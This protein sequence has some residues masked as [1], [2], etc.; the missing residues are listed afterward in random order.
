MNLSLRS[1]AAGLL[2]SLALTSCSTSSHPTKPSAIALFN[3]RDLAGWKHVLADPAV[4][5]DQVWSVTDGVIVCRGTPLGYLGTTRDFTNFRLSVEYRWAPGTKPGNSG[6]FS[7]I[8]DPVRALPRCAEVQLMH[9]NAGD[10]LTLQGMRLGINQARYFHV[11]QHEVAGDIDGVKKTS[12][13]EAA[14]GSWNRVEVQAEG[15]LYRVWLNGTLVNEVTG[16]ET[17]AG[18]IG[19]QSEGGEIHF[20]NVTVFPL[21]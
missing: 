17:L 21:P 12:D 7:R 9:G 14:P 15:P 19:L 2:A 6:L 18:P 13:A 11:A 5:R 10:V 4:P 20:R 1:L 16:V 3:G 8:N